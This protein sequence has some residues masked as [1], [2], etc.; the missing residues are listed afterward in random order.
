MFKINLAL[1]LSLLSVALIGLSG[2]QN[3]P[4]SQTPEASQTAGETTAALPGQGVTIRPANSEWLEEQFLTEIVNIGLEKLGYQVETIK[5]ADYGI[6]ITSV[7]NGDLDYTTAYYE[8]GQAEMFENAGGEAKLEAMGELL[9]DG[10]G[11]GYLI[12]KKTADQYQITDVQQLTDP[13]IAQLFDTDGDGTANLT[14]CQVGWAC[15][16][17]INNHLKAYKLTETVEQDEGQYSALLADVLARHKQGQPILYYAYIPHWIFSTLKPDQDVVWLEVPFTSFPEGEAKLT[18]KETT[19]N[20]KNLGFPLAR[21]RILANE[22]FV[23]ANPAAKRWFELVEIPAQD[24]NDVSL[25]I[26]DGKSTPEDLRVMAEAWVSQNQ[27]V[28]DTWLT[29]AKQ[30]SN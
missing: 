5:Q 1:P 27:D 3:S 25:Q 15:N 14:G 9:P 4:S 26:R 7:A 19:V 12:D 23:Q 29:E 20:G 10:G 17:V 18:E 21:P 6:I 13:E 16:K 8:V 22:E 2:C 11:Q 30:T 24:L 28:F